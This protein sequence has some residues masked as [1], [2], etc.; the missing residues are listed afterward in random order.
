M[1]VGIREDIGNYL[2][3]EE[4]NTKI[5]VVIWDVPIYVDSISQD[6]NLTTF[7]FIAD[8]SYENVEIN[9]ENYL[10]TPITLGVREENSDNS[11][12]SI[13]LT[14]SNKWQEWAA[15][16]ANNGDCFLGKFC[17]IYQWFPDYP[18]EKP[19]EMYKGILNNIKMTPNEFK[20]TVVRVLGDYEQEAPLM[21]FQ[22]NCQYVFRGSKCL[23]TGP[24]VNCEKTLQDC[25]RKGNILNF[26]GFPSVPQ[27]FLINK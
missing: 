5:L 24:D 12:E 21:T 6:K 2:N 3:Q 16:L 15:I 10:A 13:D 27:E 14:F 7:R 18:D 25:K 23:Y 11:I 22:V 20:V 17:S 26:G 9:G 8:E 19:I 1:T 4:I